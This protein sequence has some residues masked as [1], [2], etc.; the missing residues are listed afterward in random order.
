M[1]TRIVLK[2]VVICRDIIVCG[3]GNKND[4]NVSYKL[5]YIM[6]FYE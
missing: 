2:I 6:L 4:G 5:P 1:E 3:R